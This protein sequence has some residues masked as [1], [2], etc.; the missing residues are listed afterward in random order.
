[1]HRRTIRPRLAALC[2]FTA[3]AA[4]ACATADTVTEALDRLPKADVEIASGEA[5]HRFRVWVAATPASRSRG[6]MFVRELAADRGM[7]FLFDP[8]QFVS[9]WMQN[10]YVS[11]DLLFVAADGRIVNIAER[12]RP[13]STDPIESV[14]PVSGVL[15]VVAGTAQRLGIRPGDVLLH[16]AFG[17]SQP[18]E[19]RVDADR[20][21]GP[22]PT[23][24]SGN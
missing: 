17:G 14:A 1:M 6:L 3:L 15:E 7:L 4:S 2:L 24:P 23:G 19:S 8:P 18:R 22:R 11:L 21:R 16:P 10:T 9:F 20:V 12:T 13:L 5:R